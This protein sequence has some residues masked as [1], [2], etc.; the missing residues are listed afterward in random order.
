MFLRKFKNI[1]RLT[2]AKNVGRA[3]FLDVAKRSKI[4]LD[5]QIKNVW[6]TMFDRL[7]RALNSKHFF[8][9]IA[10]PLNSGRAL[11]IE[12]VSLTCYFP[13]IKKIDALP[14]R[15][16]ISWLTPSNILRG[17]SSSKGFFKYTSKNLHQKLQIYLQIAW[18]HYKDHTMGRKGLSLPH[19]L[20]IKVKQTESSD[21]SSLNIKR[22]AEQQKCAQYS[23]FHRS[24]R[25]TIFFKLETLKTTED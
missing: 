13:D 12:K 2:Q 5:K 7:A 15:W 19:G 4:V 24:L 6:P 20:N 8:Q 11:L 3:M 17:L 9:S 1:V 25:N 10:D 23:Q 16:Q 21:I 18:Q 14:C 22:E